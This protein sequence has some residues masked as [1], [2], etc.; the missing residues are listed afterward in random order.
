MFRT[1]VDATENE[2]DG[3]FFFYFGYKQRTTIPIN[4]K[5]AFSIVNQEAFDAIRQIKI[6]KFVNGI[7][8]SISSSAY[9]EFKY[10]IDSIQRYLAFVYC[11]YILFP[12][13]SIT[14]PDV[15]NV[16]KST[17]PIMVPREIQL[18]RNIPQYL[19]FPLCDK[20]RD[21]SVGL[22]VSVI[23]PGP[24][25]NGFED[26][27]RKIKNKSLIICVPRSV[28]FCIKNGVH[29]DFVVNLDT[30]S[31]MQYVLNDGPDLK[32]TYL[33]ALSPGPI[34]E[35]ATHYRGI[36]FMESFDTNILENKFRLK[37]SWLSCAISALGLA[38][39]L[40]APKVFLLGADHSWEGETKQS[41]V[42]W[43][44]NS[45]FGG[46]GLRYRQ[47]PVLVTNLFDDANSNGNVDFSIFSLP[48]RNGM[49]VN[50]FFHYFSTS[51]E[52]EYVAK[53]ME[54]QYGTKFYLLNESGILPNDIFKNNGMK[55]LLALP[56]I[57]RPVVLKKI[58]SSMQ[59]GE[60]INM[61]LLESNLRDLVKTVK[62]ETARIQFFLSEGDFASA[63]KH[64]FVDSIVTSS[65]QKKFSVLA[66][67]EF[68]NGKKKNQGIRG[69]FHEETVD[70][71]TEEA[72]YLH[73]ATTISACNV[74]LSACDDALFICKFHR[75]IKN[76]EDIVVWC[77][78]EEDGNNAI[79]LLKNK[80]S[81]IN[82][83]LYAVASPDFMGISFKRN[84]LLNS[85]VG[86]FSFVRLSYLYR[87]TCQLL[88]KNVKEKYNGI[89][90][91]IE[92]GVVL[93]VEK[94]LRCV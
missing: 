34:A 55:E 77:V 83:R 41:W 9:V 7:T 25:L 75:A 90:E 92:K 84:R 4:R 82:V 63:L 76:D 59:R 72:K 87:S 39:V 32:T 11:K 68:L 60:A 20:L 45:L 53:D 73:V 51:V 23:L 19:K 48:N 30:A 86:E 28:D 42:Y 10:W 13:K 33:V 78:S 81:S 91:L 88:T 85:V 16:R 21:A 58:D 80:F 49:L 56:D 70:K 3:S 27:I 93:E 2:D 40:K 64:P 31:R 1:I 36:F 74:W 66:D 47:D 15:A 65:R 38:A 14:I 43:N 26:I 57:D 67:Y 37:E 79:K 46:D 89:V 5:C 24:S 17:P 71:F 18:A 44:N 29:P 94:L 69:E 8:V 62:K 50:T 52:L 22:P 12:R 54:L 61:A 6:T 35:V